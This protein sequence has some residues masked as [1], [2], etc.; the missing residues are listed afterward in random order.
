MLNKKRLVDTAN[1]AYK[2]ANNTKA[3]TAE[4]K[5]FN[6][7]GERFFLTIL[8]IAVIFLIGIA[9]FSD[10]NFQTYFSLQLLTFILSITYIYFRLFR[11]KIYDSS[12]APIIKLISIDFNY[13]LFFF[14]VAIGIF[15]LLFQ[16]NLAVAFGWCHVNAMPIY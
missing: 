2:K 14:I 3:S 12:A 1:T 4:Y 6:K 10:F 11:S 9:I 15:I 7:I 5:K 8:T 13:I 16:S